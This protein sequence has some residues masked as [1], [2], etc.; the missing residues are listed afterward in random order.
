[1]SQRNGATFVESCDTE[2]ETHELPDENISVVCTRC[3][4]CAWAPERFRCAEVLFQSKIYVLAD[5]D[6]ITVALNVSVPRKCCSS[7][8]SVVSEPEPTTLLSR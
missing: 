6:I 3:S 1:M 8:I 2:L 7:H 5:G 4:R